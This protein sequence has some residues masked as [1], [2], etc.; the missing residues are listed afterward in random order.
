MTEPGALARRLQRFDEGDGGKA[1]GFE[2]DIEHVVPVAL[3]HIKQPHPGVDAG[4]VD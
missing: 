3:A 4:V 2:I 1:A